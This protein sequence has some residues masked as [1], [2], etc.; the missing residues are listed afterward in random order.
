M[1]F[2]AL[3]FF[4]ATG[5]VSQCTAAVSGEKNFFLTVS[6]RAFFCTVRN[7][8]LRCP[9]CKI[10]TVSGINSSVS[11]C[12]NKSISFTVSGINP[13]V[14]AGGGSNRILS[15]AGQMFLP[16][17]LASVPDIPDA[18]RQL[19][20]VYRTDCPAERPPVISG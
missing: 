11:Q 12:R 10:F 18:V 8:F 17:R 7:L 19:P 15:P 14:S 4:S 13:S 2:A 9:E 5:I 1:F 20:E 16:V 6:V 3:I